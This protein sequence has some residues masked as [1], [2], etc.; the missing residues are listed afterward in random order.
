MVQQA[1][2]KNLKG[3][4]VIV[5]AH[6]LSTIENADKIIVIDRGR[7]AEQG[8][9]KELLKRAGIYAQLV[10]KQLYGNKEEDDGESISNLK[11]KSRSS[12]PQ[13]VM[14]SSLSILQS[15]YKSENYNSSID[16]EF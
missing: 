10:H 2:H 6:R 11:I 14:P 15:H 7:I 3:H 8:T 16:N 9:H 12:T 1:I 5:I 13:N 4:T